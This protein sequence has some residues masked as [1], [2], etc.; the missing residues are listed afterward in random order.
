MSKTIFIVSENYIERMEILNN[1]ENFGKQ[2]NYNVSKENEAANK[3]EIDIWREDNFQLE[4]IIKN[5]AGFKDDI[6]NSRLV[7]NKRYYHLI[8][9]DF[10]SGNLPYLNQ[11]IK[12]FLSLHPDMLVTDEYRKDF[13]SIEQIKNKQVPEWLLV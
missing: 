11:F 4:F 7:K 6:S 1:V 2:N 3:G 13:Y 5:E 10:Y 8:I 9:I 12:Y